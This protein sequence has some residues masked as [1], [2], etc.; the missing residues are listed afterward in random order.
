MT[1]ACVDV[2][3]QFGVIAHRGE[4]QG[5]PEVLLREL[6]VASVV[7]HP[8][9]HLGERCG[10]AEPILAAVDQ[11]GADLVSQISDDGSV[12]VATANPAVSFSE[13]LHDAFDCGTPWWLGLDVLGW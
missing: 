5:S 9:G 8:T 10:C 3:R 11:A 13:R 1:E 7:G 4:L 2:C 6:V 12:H